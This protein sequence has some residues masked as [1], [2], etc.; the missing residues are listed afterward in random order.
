[1]TTVT[2]PRRGASARPRRGLPAGLR[3]TAPRTRAERRLTAAAA[4][5]CLCLA[6]ATLWSCYVLAHLGD[7]RVVAPRDQLA[8]LAYALPTAGAG[9]MLHAHRPGS[10][11]GWVMLFYGLAVILPKAVA[12]PVTVEVTDPAVVGT[13]VAL[14]AVCDTAR[15]TLFFVLPLLLLRPAH[16]PPVVDLHR[17]GR[18]LAGAGVHVVPGREPAVRQG[19]PA[20]GH[21]PG[22][23]LMTLYERV[24]VHDDKVFYLLVGI[25]AAVLLSRLVRA[26]PRTAATSGSCW[27]PTCCGRGPRT[28]TA[29]SRPTTTGSSTGSSPRPAWSGPS[30]S[31][32]WSSG[33]AAG[34][35][36]GRP[37]GSSADCCSPPG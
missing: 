27:P 24:G 15:E 19:Q 34:G 4:V 6:L 30:P 1:M 14:K 35:S 12:A 32:T 31:P 20:G 2:T 3:R 7:P 22:R 29:G 25:A 37:G 23:F 10:P 8:V 9:M 5:A 33:T 28:P 36:T 18:A 17:G 16:R 21:P 26:A 13:A 11:L